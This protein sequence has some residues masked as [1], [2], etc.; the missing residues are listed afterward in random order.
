MILGDDMSIDDL[1]GV[2]GIVCKVHTEK[3]TLTRAKRLLEEPAES[4]PGGPILG[5]RCDLNGVSPSCC[6]I[7]V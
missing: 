4:R 2:S 1:F 7:R 6:S 5:S 3:A